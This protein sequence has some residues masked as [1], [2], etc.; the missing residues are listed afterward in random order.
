[1][2][3]RTVRSY[4][5]DPL[6]V[7]HYVEA[8]TRLGLWASEE[9]IMTR[10]FKREET[11]L[12][13]GCGAGRIAFGLWEL[14]YRHILGF[15][16]SREMIMEARRMAR[17]LEYGISFRVD[18]ATRLDF[19]AASF[20]GA[21]FGFNGLMQ[22]PGRIR[23]QEALSRIA[24][25]LRPGAIF[26]FTTHDRDLNRYRELWIEERRLWETGKQS[27]SLLEFGDRHF[28]TSHG[29][30]YIHIPDREEV[31]EDLAATGFELLET[32]L[33]SDLASES[34]EVREFSEDCR[35]WIVRKS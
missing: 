11:L 16:F 35:F 33:R 7:Q 5:R 6:A 20:D 13:C 4:F 34:A 10:V 28:T 21:I 24:A 14:G 30:I 19:E 29:T 9:R 17:I 22:I 2:D 25:V 27:A 12:E 1:M 3:E 32:H 18:D 31:F 26:V 8:A 15:D 23:R